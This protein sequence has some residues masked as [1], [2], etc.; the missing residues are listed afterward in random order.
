MQDRSLAHRSLVVAGLLVTVAG[1][2]VVLSPR[3]LGVVE[4]QAGA[5]LY[6][7]GPGFPVHF[8]PD[9]APLHKQAI[10]VAETYLFH[11]LVEH[12]P[13]KVLLDPNV[14]RFELGRCTAG[15]CRSANGAA[16]LRQALLIPQN[17]VISG[18]RTLRWYVE[19]AKDGP[20]EAIAFYD[21]DVS[22]LEPRPPVY[23]AE[24]FQ[25]VHGLIKQI[26]VAGINMF[27]AFDRCGAACFRDST[28]GHA[29]ITPTP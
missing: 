17:R 3:A 10:D 5:G 9:L 14:A 24:R 12:D 8:P 27:T 11:G 2:V 23:I 28:V 29:V 26:E 4:G 22:A 7:G 16:D 21:L 6:P 18:I 20:C 1:A 19:C 25:I 13:D 15:S